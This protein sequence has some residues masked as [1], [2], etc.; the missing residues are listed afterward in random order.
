MKNNWNGF[1]KKSTE[2]RLKKVK[3]RAPPH[4]SRNSKKS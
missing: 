2:E 1:A 4:F 3:A